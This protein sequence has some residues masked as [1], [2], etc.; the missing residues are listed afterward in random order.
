MFL[1]V[2]TT[3]G[4]FIHDAQDLLQIDHFAEYLIVG[5]LDWSINNLIAVGSK[6]GILEIWD[7]R[8]RKR[9]YELSGSEHISSVVWSPDGNLLAT[10]GYDATSRVWDA[11]SGELVYA[12]EKVEYHLDSRGWSPDSQFIV[13]SI[14]GSTP[15][16]ITIWD[17]NTGDVL[18]VWP[19][20]LVGSDLEWSP[21][22]QFVAENGSNRINLWQA[23]T[24][25]IAENIVVGENVSV[26]SVDWHPHLSRLASLSRF[27][28]KKDGDQC[29]TYK[30][31][32]WDLTS[33]ET[34][35]VSHDAIL[36][37]DS[38]TNNA[39]AWSPN[40]S[41]LAAI[42]DNGKVYIWDVSDIARS[43]AYEGY[44]SMLLPEFLLCSVEK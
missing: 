36:T 7:T 16:D 44:A 38:S 15:R 6:D 2:G 40:G 9:V 24:G 12:S 41:R 29:F 28:V 1:A 25:E 17:A 22:G 37:F 30:T 31:Q 33:G 19:G 32:I 23:S 8:T 14:Y 43:I 21:D 3:S 18:R 11:Q 10:G 42:S 26:H 13:S 5:G 4:V 27:S 39:L 34:T 20:Q 35:L